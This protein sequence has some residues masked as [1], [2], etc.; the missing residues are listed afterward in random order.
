ME[1]L[2]QIGWNAN[3]Q[4]YTGRTA[5]ALAAS[6]GGLEAVNYLITNGANISIADIHGHD[7]LKAA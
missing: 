4:D 5:V 3:A 2:K 6:Q 1:N 7:A